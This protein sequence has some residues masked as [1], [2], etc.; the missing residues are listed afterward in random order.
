MT[1]SIAELAREAVMIQDACNPL[2]LSKGYA[3]ALQELADA[4]REQGRYSHEEIE[5]HPVNRLWLFKLCDL[6]GL[7]TDY[8]QFAPAWSEANAMA[9]YATEGR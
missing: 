4:L 5:R 8:A 3:A 1:R 7:C 9:A 2:G 6:A